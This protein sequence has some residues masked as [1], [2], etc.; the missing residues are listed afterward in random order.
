M[1][2]DNA[3]TLEEIKS[4]AVD[5]ERIPIEEVFEQLKCTRE[6]HK[7]EFVEGLKERKHMCAM[8]GNGVNDAPSLKKADIGMAVP[9]ATDAARLLRILSASF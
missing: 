4:E 7:C 3:I 2:G 6:E 8:T 5:L 9:D 1:G